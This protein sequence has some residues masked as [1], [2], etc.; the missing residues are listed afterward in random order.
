MSIVDVPGFDDLTLFFCCG[1]SICSPSSPLGIGS[2]FSALRAELL[3]SIFRAAGFS[4]V[5]LR[6]FLPTGEAT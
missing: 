5:I 2:A 6:L 3:V 4:G 1:S